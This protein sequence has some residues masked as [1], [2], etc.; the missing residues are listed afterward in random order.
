MSNVVK[1]CSCRGCRVGR[2]SPAGKDTVRRTLR[3]YRHNVKQ[4]LRQGK[5]PARIVSVGYTD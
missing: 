1:F 2:R 5:E 4:A 3:T